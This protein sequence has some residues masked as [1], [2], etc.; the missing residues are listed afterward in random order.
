LRKVIAFVYKGDD[1][2]RVIFD[3]A[4]QVPK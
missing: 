4:H 2:E 1:I 3:V